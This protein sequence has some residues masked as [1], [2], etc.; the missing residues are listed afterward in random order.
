MRMMRWSS[1]G[2]WLIP[3][4]GVTPFDQV[5]QMFTALF[6]DSAFDVSSCMVAERQ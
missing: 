5:V 6:S 3:M 2:V 4:Q 1:D